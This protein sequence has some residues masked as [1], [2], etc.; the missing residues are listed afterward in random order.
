MGRKSL[1]EEK[2]QFLLWD[3]VHRTERA[4]LGFPLTYEDMAK[5][6]GVSSASLLNWKKSCLMRQGR[7]RVSPQKPSVGLLITRNISSGVSDGA[8]SEEDR[9]RVVQDRLFQ[10][11]EKSF[12]AGKEYLKATGNYIEKSDV[13]M[14]HNFDASEYIEIASEVLRRIA[15]VLPERCRGVCPLFPQQGLLSGEVREGELCGEGD[16]KLQRSLS[17]EGGSGCDSDTPPDSNS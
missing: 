4:V 2:K 12:M 10:Q 8:L 14:E 16:D 15:E 5:K 7:G 11:S 17:R 3:A 13:R 6:L 9:V 1:L